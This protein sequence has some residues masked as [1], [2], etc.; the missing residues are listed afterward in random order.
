MLPHD[1]TQYHVGSVAT[2][3]TNLI[4]QPGQLLTDWQWH[5]V[6]SGPKELPYLQIKCAQVIS[7]ECNCE[8]LSEGFVLLTLR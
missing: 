1:S 8:Q 4:M 2:S 6:S 5:E 7:T 3:Q